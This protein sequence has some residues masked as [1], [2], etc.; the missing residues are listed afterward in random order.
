MLHGK[1]TFHAFFQPPQGISFCHYK[2]SFNQYPHMKK[3][4]SCDLDKKDLRDSIVAPILARLDGLRM[5][6]F[7]Q[8]ARMSNRLHEIEDSLEV[9]AREL[10]TKR[11]DETATDEP[12]AR[13][14]ND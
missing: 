2:R 12:S 7:R 3:L 6:S 8:H 5:E 13:P 1:A 11:D 14:K 4:F 9:I 10:A